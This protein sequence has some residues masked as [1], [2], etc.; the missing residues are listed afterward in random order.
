MKKLRLLAGS[1]FALSSA[2][3]LAQDAPES[4]LPPGFDNPAPAPAPSPPPA[5]SAPNVPST[6]SGSS[7]GGQPRVIQVVPSGSSQSSSSSSNSSAT[8]TASGGAASAVSADPDVLARLPSLEELEQMTPEEFEEVLGLKPKFDIP[9]AARR[10]LKQ[11]GI[12]NM[13]E[14]GFAPASLASQNGRLVRS[15]LAGNRGVLV[16]RWGH[17]LLRRAL[18]SRLDTPSGISPANFAALRA[19]L[20]LR[21][22]EA[23]AARAIVQDLDTGNY[24]PAIV[25]TAFDAYV[26]T[27]DFTGICAT[28]ITQGGLR[29]DPQW[30]TARSICSA[31]RGDSNGAFVRLDRAIRN[32]EMPKIDLLLA[33][34]YAG[35]AGRARRAVTIEWDGVTDMTPWRFGLTNAVGLEPPEKLMN[36]ANR[37][38]ANISAIAPMVGLERRAQAADHAAGAGVLSSTAMVDLYSQIYSAQDISGDWAD[39]AAQLREAYTSSTSATRLLAMQ[40]LWNS[41]DSQTARYSR[42]VLTAYAA[43]RLPVNPEMS[44][45]A[46]DLIASMLAAG[47]DRNALR[48]A[49]VA[50]TGSQAWGLLVLAAPN[51]TKPVGGNALEDYFGDDQSVERRKSAFLLAGLAGLG[52]VSADTKASLSKDLGIDLDRPSRWTRVINREAERNNQAMVAILAGLGMQGTGWDKMTPRYL[53]TIVS[54]LRKVGLEPEAR[55][56]AAEALARA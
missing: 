53:Y 24:T 5:V 32:E 37:R 52:R 45:A 42:Q 46:P 39:R 23:E 25:D 55:M 47:L 15:A 27:A 54:A 2:W 3:L 35:A 12:I 7:T 49:Q 50:G 30:E 40:Q 51:R 48:W 19:A 14:G 44:Q 31:F 20:L 22:G 43:A 6:S 10:S 8:P 38:Y 17:I 11:V 36:A 1:A 18:S 29:K 21:M 16:S 4:L 33:Q 28:M 13:N 9:P 56:I 34:K 26:A 41:T